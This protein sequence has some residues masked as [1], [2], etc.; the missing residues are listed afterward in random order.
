MGALGE[1]NE[2]Q[3]GALDRPNTSPE[4]GS[5]SAPHWDSASRRRELP[6][7]LFLALPLTLSFAGQ[8]LL[9]LVDTFVAG[10]LGVQALA[11]T[12]AGG[13]LFWLGSVAPLGIMLSMDPLSSQA[14]GAG[15]QRRLWLAC[16]GGL[17]YALLLSLA[18]L[19]V[20]FALLI[21]GLP[22]VEG[23]VGA[24]TS[25]YLL[26]RAFGVLPFLSYITLRCHLQAQ[27]VTAPILFATALANVLNFPLS[28]WLGGGAPLLESL[29]LPAVSGGGYGVWGIGL[30]SAIASLLEALIL[31]LW[32]VRRARRFP[33]PCVA[34]WQEITRIGLPIGG[35]LLSEGGIFSAVT[36]L[37]GSW[38]VGAVSAHQITLQ[39]AS[40]TFTLCLGVSSATAVRVGYWIGA[41]APA[42]SHFAARCGLTVGLTM[43]SCSAL[44]FLGSG[45]PL[46]G[47]LTTDGEVQQLATALLMIAAAFQLFDALQVIAAGALRG[48]GWTTAPLYIAA[49][50]HWGIGLPIGLLLAYPGGMEIRGL[51][52]GLV[53]GLSV[54]GLS[55]TR[56]FFKR[57]SRLSEET[58]R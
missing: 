29:G 13:A 19:L 46:A 8:Q 53:A 32:T 33:W 38:G 36:L 12:G 48:A 11:A 50:S 10:R 25:A 54:A 47:L 43:M 30:A 3:E 37:A 58:G 22:W 14:V 6:R 4:R 42:G 31:L 24:E 18:T 52:W 39:L 40:F 23:E 15:D 9:S 1:Q 28:C 57:L 49:I 27:N 41:E 21:P 26:G 20:L 17:G 16:R 2:P 56:S 34:L 45:G 51:W 5:E 35:A 44:I 7:L 55:M